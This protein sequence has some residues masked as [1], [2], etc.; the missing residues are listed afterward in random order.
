[1]Q[2]SWGPAPSLLSDVGPALPRPTTWSPGTQQ[3]P[4]DTPFNTS[5]RFRLPP[6]PPSS[7]S[8]S[9]LGEKLKNQQ[10]A[11]HSEALVDLGLKETKHPLPLA[12]PHSQLQPSG[13]QAVGPDDTASRQDFETLLR[14]ECVWGRRWRG[15]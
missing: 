15:Y 8:C 2:D 6:P 11:V 10:V 5:P 13:T 9:Q 14:S 12:H 1:M 4:G 3:G 7:W